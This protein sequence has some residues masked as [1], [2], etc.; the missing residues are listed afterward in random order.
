METN[1]SFKENFKKILLIAGW[2]VV[3][4]G[5]MVLLVAAI[6]RKNSKTCKSVKV[7]INGGAQRIDVDQKEILRAMTADGMIKLEGKT[8]ASFDLRKMEEQLKR[9]PW[10]KDAQLFF[11]NNDALRIRVS[12][13][14]PVARIFT[15][16]GN[17]FYI[18]SGASQ[19]PLPDQM[20]V[21]LPV[22]TGYPSDKIKF[23][24]A[25]SALTQQIKKL[26]LFISGNV[27]WSA[28]IE[29]I[30]ITPNRNFEMVPVIGNH[31]IEFG[32]GNNY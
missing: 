9:N 25:D 13:R 8:I 29:Q 17:S 1:M 28:E 3:G 4:A 18:D 32:D 11:D 24:G 23:H 31:L 20:T 19:L 10:V 30:A 16:S 22:F 26:S 15:L 6:N 14:K 2:I 12:E 27:F 7:E 5:V 21:R